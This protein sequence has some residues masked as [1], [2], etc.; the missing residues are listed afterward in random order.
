[1]ANCQRRWKYISGSDVC[2]TIV[3]GCCLVNKGLVRVYSC[4]LVLNNTLAICCSCAYAFS[5]CYMMKLRKPKICFPEMSMSFGK[6]V[7]T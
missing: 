6:A 4:Y 2:G 1:M 3:Y 7:A 5:A